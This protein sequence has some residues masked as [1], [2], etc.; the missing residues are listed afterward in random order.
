VPVERV[1]MVKRPTITLALPVAKQPCVAT[2][3]CSKHSKFHRVG[4]VV[5]I[6]AHTEVLGRSEGGGRNRMV[7]CSYDADYFQQTVGVLPDAAAQLVSACD[8]RSRLAPSLLSRLMSEA[9]HPGFVSHAVA[10]AL[11][12]AL[13]VE[14]WHALHSKQQQYPRAQLTP[15]HF[16][17]LDEYL[18]EL[19]SEAPS[20]SAIARACGLSERHFARLFRKQTNLSIGQYLKSVQISKA[21]TYLLETDLSLKEIAYRL[22]FSAPSNFCAAFRA[23]TGDTPTRFRL[24]NRDYAKKDVTN[25]P[26]AS[27]RM[28]PF[29]LQ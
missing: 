16:R 3:R 4:G 5:F 14:C 17:I 6:P 26:V 20:V 2:Y 18:A 9:L 22:G 10:E 27:P 8:I 24:M 28:S 11:G 19:Q 23:G 7:S 1:F 12:H 15:R 29:P 25:G 13:L 21:Q